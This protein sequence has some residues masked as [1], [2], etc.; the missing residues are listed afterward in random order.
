ML[1]KDMHSSLKNKTF[2]LS[3]PSAAPFSPHPA[4]IHQQPQWVDVDA[5][6]NQSILIVFYCL[7]YFF[8]PS[9]VLAP[10]CKSGLSNSS[11]SRGHMSE[12]DPKWAGLLKTNENIKGTSTFFTVGI[13]HT[14]RIGPSGWLVLAREPYV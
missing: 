1:C 2:H 10:D 7:L 6:R 11:Q 3:T 9:L 8:T 5:L 14:G 12:F 4:A 13:C